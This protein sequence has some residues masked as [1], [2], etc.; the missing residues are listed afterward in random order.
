MTIHKLFPVAIGEYHYDNCDDLKFKLLS[1]SEKYT[2]VVN[3]TLL[4]GE[5]GG[6]VDVH[7]DEEFSS[8]LPFIKQSFENYFDSLCFDHRVFDIIISKSWFNVVHHGVNT[9]KHIHDTSH[10]SFVYYINLPENSDSLHFSVS[11][12]PNEP[13]QGAFYD[14]G[15]NSFFKTLV[16][17]YN[18]CNSLTWSFKN[19]EGDLFIFPSHLEHFTTQ[20][21]KQPYQGNRVVF[22]GD[23]FLV[24]KETLSPNYPTGIFPVKNWKVL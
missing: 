8:L 17:N 7:N 13:F 6:F 5:V 1:K 15:E 22:S 11:R 3:D 21:S 16:Y 4:T 19:K 12:N 18:D 9:P 24:Y 2:K 20:L 23:V 14:H 10:F